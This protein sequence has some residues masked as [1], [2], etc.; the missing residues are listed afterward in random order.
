MLWLS[1]LA[2]FS[3]KGQIVNIFDSHMFLSFLFL[4]F[5]GEEGWG[6]LYKNI[7]T[8][9]G[10]EAIQE[11][12]SC[13]PDLPVGYSLPTLGP[14]PF[15]VAIHSYLLQNIKDERIFKCPTLHFPKE[16]ISLKVRVY[17]Q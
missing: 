13:G 7:K 16:L 11:K 2:S 4:F 15:K 3:V 14:F 8:I 9:L 10:T 1:G 6:R 17:L 12:T 5:V